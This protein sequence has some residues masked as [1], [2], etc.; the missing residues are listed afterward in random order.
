MIT[1]PSY[2]ASQFTRVADES[3]RRRL[4]S[5]STYQLTVPS[6]RLQSER[7]P[8][9]SAPASGMVCRQMILLRPRSRCL[10]NV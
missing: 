1:A 10:D 3:T 6:Y 5:V 8:F 7:G 2:L 4:R 9:W